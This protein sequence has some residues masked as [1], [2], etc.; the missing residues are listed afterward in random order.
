MKNSVKKDK[1]L[2]ILK[3]GGSIITI[4]AKFETYN[5]NVVKKLTDSLNKIIDL[6]NIIIVHG[7]GSFGHYHAKEY[8]IKQGFKDPNQLIGVVKTHESM[9]KLNNLFLN[10]LKKSTSIYPISFSP[11]SFTNTANGEIKRFEISN[12]K[13]ALKLGITPILFGDVVFDEKIDFTIL[14]GDKIV[15]Y[16]AKHLKPKKIVMLTDVEGVYDDNPSK[17]KNAKLLSEINL[18]D[19][20]MLHKISV[21]ADSG[22]TRVTGEMGKKLLELRET[23]QSGIETWIISGLIENLLPKLILEN[24]HIGTKLFCE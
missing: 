9:L 14:S 16:L 2:L 13:S 23:V 7:A 1:P 17:N 12:I 15:P 8:N 5:E 18:N 24:E 3:F 10:S 19:K 20:E 21:N 11:I 4:D 22:K 6:Y